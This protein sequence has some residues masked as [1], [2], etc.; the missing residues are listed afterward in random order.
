MSIRRACSYVAA[1]TLPEGAESYTGLRV[2]ISQK[3]QQIINKEREDLELSGYTA[4][5][6]LTQEETLQL[7]EGFAQIQIRA[8]K[9]PYVAPGSK[10]FTVDV[11]PSL[12]EEVFED[13]V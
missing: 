1:F 13:G 10:V 11:L 8:Y 6:K 12:N 5:L 3:R 7:E 4:T 9:A 2:T